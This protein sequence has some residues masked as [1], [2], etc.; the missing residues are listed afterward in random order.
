MRR[1]LL[2]LMAILCLLFSGCGRQKIEENTQNELIGYEAST[3][4]VPNLQGTIQSVLKI[5]SK[6]YAGVYTKG[7][8]VEDG[9]YSVVIYDTDDGTHE[10]T[11][12]QGKEEMAMWSFTV[13]EDGNYKALFL[14][15][16]VENTNYSSLWL[17]TFD[18]QGRVIEEQELTQQVKEQVQDTILLD[19]FCLD[20]AG[21][22]YFYTTTYGDVTIG[23]IS[24]MSNIY[25]TGDSG[26]VQLIKAY[27]GNVLELEEV[28]SQVWL[29]VEEFENLSQE[30]L[31]YDLTNRDTEDNQID[32]KLDV[33]AQNF[34]ISDGLTDT[35]KFI[36]QN[37][38]VYEYDLNSQQLV[39]LFTY[40]DVGLEFGT[41]NTGKL[42]ATGQDEFYVLK[43]IAQTEEGI[44]TYDWVKITKSAEASQKEILTI[45]VS[46]ESSS[47]RE[48]VVAFN[49]SSEQYKAVVKVYDAELLQAD[50]VAGNVPDMIATDTIDLDV[51]LNKGLIHDL[52]DLLERDTALSKDDFV[53][54][55]LEIYKR[56]DELYAIPENVSITSLIG[57]EKLLGGRESWNIQEFEE[58]V[59]SL[60]NERAA[61]LGISKD[62]MLQIIMEQ[63]MARFVD[64]ENKLC[65]F[66]S[67]EFA[68]L[69]EF[70]NMYPNEGLDVENDMAKLVE[71]FRSDEI[72]L[73]PYGIISAYDY[74]LMKALWGEEIVYIGYPSAEGNGI[75]LVDTGAAYVIAEN[76]VHKEEM[77]Q[78]IKYMV[79]NPKLADSGLPAYQPLFDK[80]CEKAMEKNMVE[81][82]DGTVVEAP[83][84]EMEVEGMKLEIY[85]ATED[86]IAMIKELF[87]KAE[88]V[89]ASSTIIKNI[90][91]E[92]AQG[93][94]NGQKTVEDV[95]SVVQ[96][97]VST[98]LNE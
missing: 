62:L 98:Y 76:S 53:G 24:I 77:W 19:S 63:Y 13:L 6:L 39:S 69:L 17:L 59:H 25:Y 45:A 48:A 29:A 49:Q 71:M 52:S 47:L 22:L 93:Y 2:F 74:Q 90:I 91:Q 79:T 36:V 89:I 78:I 5:D 38:K 42:I 43:K 35:Q 55:T 26:E 31:I 20:R 81:A 80:A 37:A 88:P 28:S 66:E 12:L 82:A 23:D 58:Y 32:L 56:G 18:C 67:E 34:A 72:I 16:D 50:I 46:E 10:R 27:S 1:K 95:I 40:E 75:Q 9:R 87:E 70:I 86:D 84:L 68:E 61:T 97:R 60:P 21:N 85:A 94:F 83:V 44:R 73:Y 96:N 64:W 57:K 14:V 30:I 8:A 33:Q 11:I 3:C 15:Q 65:S 92:E 51:M 54:R 7:T 4:G 41:N